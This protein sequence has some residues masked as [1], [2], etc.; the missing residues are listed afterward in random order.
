MISLVLNI[1]R[2]Y[3]ESTRAVIVTQIGMGLTFLLAAIA[4]AG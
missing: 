4:L 3:T 1:V 2:V